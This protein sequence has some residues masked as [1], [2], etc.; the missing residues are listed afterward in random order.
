MREALDE[1]GHLFLVDDQAR[2][3]QFEELESFCVKH[4]IPFDRHSGAR[5]E[6]DAANVKFRPGMKRPAEV[7][8]NNDGDALVCAESIRTIAKEL[9][10]LVTVK[11]TREK[12]LAAVKVIQHLNSLLPSE[13]EPLPPFEIEE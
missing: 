10:R 5:H 3:G 1:D 4:G 11:V 6:F 2:C 13:I 12:L 8:S 7:S 9:T